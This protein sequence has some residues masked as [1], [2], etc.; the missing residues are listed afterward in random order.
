MKFE[1][2]SKRQITWQHQLKLVE[3][4]RDK[5]KDYSVNDDD[6]KTWFDIRKVSLKQVSESEKVV[7]ILS[8]ESILQ[9]KA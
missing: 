3:F 8:D 9:C 2:K 6:W 4:I 1:E 5:F 7:L